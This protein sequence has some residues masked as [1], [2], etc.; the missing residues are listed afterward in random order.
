MSEE[1]HTRVR[2]M[3]NNNHSV[4]YIAT[5]CRVTPELVKAILKQPV[6]TPRELSARD[7]FKRDGFAKILR[8]H[9]LYK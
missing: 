2:R 6:D 7:K 3:A 5:I 9:G 1:L 4:E 8:K